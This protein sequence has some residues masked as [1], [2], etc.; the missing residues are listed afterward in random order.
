MGII[1]GDITFE[2]CINTNNRPNKPHGLSLYT[3]VWGG[4]GF[5]SK[6]NRQSSPPRPTR[7][8]IIFA[9]SS[10]VLTSRASSKFADCQIYIYIYT[11]IH[12]ILHTRS[13]SSETSLPICRQ[14]YLRPSL[15][16]TFKTCVGKLWQRDRLY[17]NITTWLPSVCIMYNTMA[18]SREYVIINAGAGHV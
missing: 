14:R 10:R 6:F 8:Y 17:N 11:Y 15:F 1:R 3:V 18:N 4:G 5:R 13:S 9:I 7:A 2:C 16:Y 12:I